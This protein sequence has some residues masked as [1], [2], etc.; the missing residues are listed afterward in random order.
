M[1][2][3]LLALD[4]TGASRTIV[5]NPTPLELQNA[6]S[7]HVLGF[8]STGELLVAESEGNFGLD[9]WEAVVEHGTLLC[10]G[11]VETA[12]EKMQ[13]EGLEEQVSMMEFVKSA[14]HEKV[15]A[16]LEWKS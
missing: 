6:A 16:D 8:A 12:D 7:V 13:E 10:C 5:Q 3:V 4:G 11:E 15:A 1:T 14:L 2:S 9:D